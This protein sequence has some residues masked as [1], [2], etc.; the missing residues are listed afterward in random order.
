[1]LSCVLTPTPSTLP[2]KY[3]RQLI[4]AGFIKEADGP[5]EVIHPPLQG[6]V[7]ENAELHQTEVMK[8]SHQPG[9]DIVAVNSNSQVCI[10]TYR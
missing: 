5:L 3:C 6:I 2:A 4:V 7:G 1:M 8:A 9:C 10:V